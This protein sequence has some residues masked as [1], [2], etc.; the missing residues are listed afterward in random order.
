MEEILSK[1]L[2]ELIDNQKELA[3]NEDEKD[4]LKTRLLQLI[5][6]IIKE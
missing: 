5:G 1:T 2:Q 3:L 6:I 4:Y